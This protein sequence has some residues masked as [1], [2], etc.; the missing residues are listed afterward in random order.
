MITID[1][2]S[3][4]VVRLEGCLVV[5]TGCSVYTDGFILTQFYRC[6]SLEVFSEWL[7]SSHSSYSVRPF[8]A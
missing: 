4:S 3:W 7:L 8:R 1:T 2:F 5:A 6:P